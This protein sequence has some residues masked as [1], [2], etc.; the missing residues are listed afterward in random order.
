[1]PHALCPDPNAPA[2]RYS[3]AL[4]SKYG[5]SALSAFWDSGTYLSSIQGKPGSYILSMQDVRTPVHS[6]SVP[7]LLNLCCQI[8]LVRFPALMEQH[9]WICRPSH[10]ALHVCCCIM[11][12]GLPSWSAGA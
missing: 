9:T 2:H 8:G 12:D 5:Q 1:M 6:P 3:V 4:V 7:H 11:Y 10:I